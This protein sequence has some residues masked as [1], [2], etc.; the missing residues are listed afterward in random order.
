[1]DDLIKEQ[2]ALISLP[3]PLDEALA[4][5]KSTTFMPSTK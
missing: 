3:E 5:A 2:T 1:M 4:L